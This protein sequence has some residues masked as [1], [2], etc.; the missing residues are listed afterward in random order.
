MS[1]DVET[2]RRKVEAFEIDDPESVESFS[3]RLARENDWTLQYT[4]RVIKEYKRFVVLAL[5]AT[6]SVTPSDAVDQAW[7]LHLLYSQSYWGDLCADTL[8]YPLHHQPSRG[9]VA[10]SQKHHAD[11]ERTLATYAASFGEAPPGDIWP[12]VAKRF[13]RGRR[14]TRVDGQGAWVLSKRATVHSIAFAAAMLGVFLPIAGW[15]ASLTSHGFLALQAALWS[16]SL[17]AA[18]WLRHGRGEREPRP[19]PDLDAYEV[20][21]LRVGPQ[22]AV[23]AAL[24]H[25]VAS[26]RLVLDA[27]KGILQIGAPLEPNAHRLEQRLYARIQA[28]QTA[29]RDLRSDARS[30]T[31][32]IHERLLEHELIAWTESPWPL[33]LALLAPLLGL[34]RVIHAAGTPAPIGFTVLLSVAGLIVAFRYFRVHSSPSHRGATLLRRMKNEH[35]ALAQLT[36][37]EARQD[38]SVQLAL[39]IG[40]FG[41]AVLPGAELSELA[42]SLTSSHAS[43]RADTRG[44]GGCGGGAGGGCGGGGCGGGGCGGC[45]GGCGG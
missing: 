45:G 42:D 28:G 9:G 7:H 29:L 37:G 13:W 43:P 36:P 20:A 27:P 39:A 11:Y 31:R 25:L 44:G 1:R 35:N 3:E 41:M 40:L 22:L 4:H 34:L 5:T 14:F 30:L 21:Q 10:E 8:D 26:E 16:A 24:S 15:G 2:V 12:T 38:G 19:M 17:M 23:D 18:W 32:D 6:H 33:R